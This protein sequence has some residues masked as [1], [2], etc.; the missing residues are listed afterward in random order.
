MPPKRGLL[1]SPLQAAKAELLRS[2]GDLTAQQ[3][4][5]VVLYNDAMH[6]FRP[7]G[8]GHALLPATEQHL[9]EA[10]EFV[11]VAPAS[12]GTHHLPPLAHA[13]KLRPEVIYL[14]TDGEPKDDPGAP[15]RR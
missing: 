9:R 13:I 2:M 5:Q 10:S 3:Q 4:F 7:R 11:L 1:V 15:A 6:L 12:G 14:L 8:R